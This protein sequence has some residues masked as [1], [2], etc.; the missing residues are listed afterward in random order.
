M[1]RRAAPR[2]PTSTVLD[3]RSGD[4]WDTVLM[5][6]LST[7]GCR[8][9]RS[10][11]FGRTDDDVVLYF[12]DRIVVE[13]AV[14]WRNHC[15]TGIEFSDKLHALVVAHLRYKDVVAHCAAERIFQF[16]ANGSLRTR[17]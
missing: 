1:D 5:D 10:E 7:G 15:C 3:C 6:E 16:P 14:V 13:G 8:I 12:S 11:P 2:Y 9:Q 4:R 17:E